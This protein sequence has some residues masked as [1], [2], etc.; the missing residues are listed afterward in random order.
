MVRRGWLGVAL[1]ACGVAAGCGAAV[2][3]WH[4]TGT[5]SGGGGAAASAGAGAGTGT[6][7]TTSTTTSASTSTTGSGGAGGVAAASYPDPEWAEAAPADENVDAALLEEAAKIAEQNQSYCLLVIRHGKLIFERYWAGHDPTSAER[8]WSIAKSYSSALVGIAIARGEIGSIDDSVAKYIPEWKGTAKEAITVRHL[9]TMSSGLK[10]SAFDDYVAMVMLAQDHS[11]YALSRAYDKAP[12]T[13]WTYDNAAV[14][15]L[16]PLFRAATGMTIE[17]YAAK[18]LWAKI[19][20]KASWAHDPAGNATA[21]ASVLASCRD[22]ARLG[23]LYLH[24]GAWKGEQVV[25]AAWVKDSLTPSQPMNQAYGRLWWLN[26]H[27]PYLSSMGQAHG[28]DMLIPFAPAD[29]FAAHG[30]GN[31]FIDVI[32][33]LDTM[34]IRFGAD[35]MNSFDLGKLF[36]DAEFVTEAAILKP[37]LAAIK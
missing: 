9:V 28:S 8:S 4:E 26:G 24:G 5:A 10:W 35:P 7:T 32:P 37:V 13:T 3:S 6:S 17:A 31:Q 18:Y 14:Q 19:G 2:D 15:V 29:L 34:V 20:A 33:S 27:T 23:Y 25:P 22:H 30:F 16:E 36:Q 12:G 1:V 21:Y 11:K